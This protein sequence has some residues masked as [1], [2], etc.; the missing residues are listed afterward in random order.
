MYTITTLLILLLPLLSANVLLDSRIHV[1]SPFPTLD[2]NTH[3]ASVRIQVEDVQCE[4]IVVQWA[5]STVYQSFPLVDS[6]LQAR[7]AVY[8][9]PGTAWVEVGLSCAD[10][11]M[12]WIYRLPVSHA[13]LCDAPHQE[14]TAVDCSEQRLIL[15]VQ[16]DSR[17]W[18]VFERQRVLLDADNPV[19]LLLSVEDE[20]PGPITALPHSA[21]CE[22]VEVDLSTLYQ[23]SLPPELC[24]SS[25]PGSPSPSAISWDEFK[26]SWVAV[27]YFVLSSGYYLALHIDY[28]HTHFV[29]G[30]VLQIFL[31]NALVVV[32]MR[33]SWTTYLVIKV[34]A[35]VTPFLFAITQAVWYL[36]KKGKGSIRFPSQSRIKAWQALIVAAILS[37]LCWIY[38]HAQLTYTSQS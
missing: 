12:L 34:A 7:H 15:T 10:E 2:T 17:W 23:R 6:N 27:C 36:Y 5:N 18:V 19:S 37:S 32:F 16:S 33:V 31:E 8:T 21:F 30:Q 4:P 3:T 9:N 24:V 26:A 20:L 22:P 28:W 11:P 13:A 1:V 38:T 25:H 14:W 29:A 35:M